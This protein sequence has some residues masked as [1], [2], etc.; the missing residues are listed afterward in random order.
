[1]ESDENS[2]EG[3]ISTDEG[4]VVVYSEINDSK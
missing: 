1:M 4:S 3:S 2:V